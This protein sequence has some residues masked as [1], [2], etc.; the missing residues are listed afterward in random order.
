MER[1]DAPRDGE[2]QPV[3]GNRV[4]IISLIK[5]I[6]DMTLCFLGDAVAIVPNHEDDTRFSFLQPYIDTAAFRR[7]LDRVVDEIEQT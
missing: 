4:R 5:L 6:E 2:P 1:N 3:A 7:K